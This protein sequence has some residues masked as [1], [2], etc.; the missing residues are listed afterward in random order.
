[1]TLNLYYCEQLK[2][3]YIISS[4]DEVSGSLRQLTKNSPLYEISYDVHSGDSLF[5][6]SRQRPQIYNDNGIVKALFFK[7][8]DTDGLVMLSNI[9]DGW[10]SI[11]YYLSR[12]CNIPVYMFHFDCTNSNDMYNGFSFLQ[13][14]NNTR[15]V[16]AMKDPKWIFFETG[17]QQWF[18]K[19]ELYTSRRIRD[20]MTKQ[21]ITQY[22]KALDLRIEN[23]E[24]W[25]PSGKSLLFTYTPPTEQ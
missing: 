25:V 23:P 20:R 5:T 24:F 7:C 8:R 19:P 13:D 2:F 1:M 18:E 22:C 10:E 4:F 11:C 3:S 12:E 17:E 21:I 9:T 6:G 14:G 16:Y 15:T